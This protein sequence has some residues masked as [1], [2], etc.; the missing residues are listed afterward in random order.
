MTNE[1]ILNVFRVA[2]VA[3]PDDYDPTDEQMYELIAYARKSGAEEMRE[4]AGRAA[5]DAAV[6]GVYDASA[7]ATLMRIVVAIRALPVE[8]NAEPAGPAAGEP[9]PRTHRADDTLLKRKPNDNGRG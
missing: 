9:S 2:W 1:E 6:A 7:A 8:P 3:H 4:E 5:C